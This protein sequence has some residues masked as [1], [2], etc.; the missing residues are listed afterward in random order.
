MFFILI[1]EFFG[2]PRLM[3]HKLRAGPGPGADGGVRG[4][5]GRVV[6]NAVREGEVGVLKSLA[7]TP[8]RTGCCC[9]NKLLQI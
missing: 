5:S 9:R 1:T 4:A 6:G 2:I 8:S 7:F 3:L